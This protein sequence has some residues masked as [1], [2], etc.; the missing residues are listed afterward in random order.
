VHQRA[1]L[2]SGGRP[3]HGGDPADDDG[4][5]TAVVHGVG[6]ALQGGQRAVE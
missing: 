6:D 4:V 5:I 3:P 2:V 1:A